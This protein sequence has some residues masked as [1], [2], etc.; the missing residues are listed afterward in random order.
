MCTEAQ[1]YT[2]AA[3]SP[4][5]RAKGPLQGKRRHFGRAA[6]SQQHSMHAEGNATS[7][8]P[9]AAYS[10]DAVTCTY[11]WKSAMKVVQMTGT[12]THRH[13]WVGSRWKAE[14]VSL[15]AKLNPSSLARF[16]QAKPKADDSLC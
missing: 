2:A 14:A 11:Y 9:A 16:H 10:A 6:A 13:I 7:A 12:A 4:R 1:A 15:H 3:R 8:Q 5:W